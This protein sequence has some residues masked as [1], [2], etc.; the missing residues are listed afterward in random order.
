[1]FGLIQA[2]EAERQIVDTARPYHLS[3]A[4]ALASRRQASPGACAYIRNLVH[5]AEPASSAFADVT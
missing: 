5:N 1:M 4:S 2:L 3:T